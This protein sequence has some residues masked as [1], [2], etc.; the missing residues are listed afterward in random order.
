MG[1]VQEAEPVTSPALTGRRSEGDVQLRQQEELA[2]LQEQFQQ[3]C[4]DVD[5][6]A[7][8]MKH[9]NVTNAQVRPSDPEGSANESSANLSDRS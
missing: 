5:Q 8:D 2:S 6:L 7:A 9:V 4:R 1:V 3:L